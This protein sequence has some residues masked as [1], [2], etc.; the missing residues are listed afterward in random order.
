MNEQQGRAVSRFFGNPLVGIIGSLASI[1]GVGLAV[2]FYFSGRA[3]PELSFYVHPIK[4][5]VVKID[6]ASKLNVRFENRDIL[7]NVTAAQVAIWN[8]GN[9]SIRT[10][11]ILKP[12]VISTDIKKSIL[13]ARVIKTSRDVVNMSLDTAQLGKGKVGIS[14]KI[15]ERGDG[16]IIQLIYEGD[17]ETNINIEGIIEGQKEIEK[18]QYSEKIKSPQE[19]YKTSRWPKFIAA[20]MLIV[21]SFLLSILVVRNTIRDGILSLLK[22]SSLVVLA[23]TLLFLILGI[24]YFIKSLEKGPPFG[25]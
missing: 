25:F 13:E 6:Q 11:N 8:R 15:L 1:L 17:P 24:Y 3:Q 23:Q 21:L 12:I 4:A 16:A 10:E 14:W 7:S 2:F 18:V 19:Q 20:M 9:K 5:T 22:I